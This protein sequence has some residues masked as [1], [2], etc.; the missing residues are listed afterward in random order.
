MARLR[1]LGYPGKTILAKLSWPEDFAFRI[2]FVTSFI[3]IDFWALIRHIF[4]VFKTRLN[5][6]FVG[7]GPPKSIKFPQG[8]KVQMAYNIIFVTVRL[9]LLISPIL[10]LIP[11]LCP[12]VFLYYFLL[13]LFSL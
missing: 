5:T 1:W 6:K 7:P 4:R 8:A 3:L 10:G 12:T 13:K 2:L 9:V 11:L